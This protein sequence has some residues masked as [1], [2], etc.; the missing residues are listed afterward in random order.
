M[1][2]LLYPMEAMIGFIGYISPFHNVCIHFL[3]SV[4]V[5][6]SKF[7]TKTTTERNF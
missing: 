1:K 7:T 6:K 5:R 3:L 4:N 2:T